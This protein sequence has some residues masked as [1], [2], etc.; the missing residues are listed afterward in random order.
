M[1]AASATASAI[2]GSLQPLAYHQKIKSLLQKEYSDVWEWFNSVKVQA[3]Y[4]EKAELELLKTTYRM[5]RAAHEDLYQLVDEVCQG[6]ELEVPVTL[7]QAQGAE[8]SSAAL[9]YTPGH[10]HVVLVGRV[11]ELLSPN[12]MKALLAHELAHFKLWESE[13]GAFLVCDQILNTMADEPRAE[14]CHHQSARLFQLYT[15]VYADAGALAVV[16]EED[17]VATLLK[18]HTGFKDADAVS[19]MKQA[20][21]IFSK[22][23]S[24]TEGITHPELFIR[25]RA[26]Q[27]M[28]KLIEDQDFGEYTAGTQELIEGKMSLN[29]LDMLGQVELERQTKLFLADHLQESWLRTED[30]QAHIG[31]FFP[32]LDISKVELEEMDL[33]KVHDSVKEYFCYLLVDSVAVNSD[34]D[35][36]AIA[37]ALFTGEKYGLTKKLTT[38]INQELKILKKDLKRIQKD[39]ESMV[40]KA[41]VEAELGSKGKSED[42]SEGDSKLP[43]DTGSLE[44]NSEVEGG[45]S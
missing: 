11:I 39:A 37:A 25:V 21:D 40:K 16:S 18:V 17:V 7:Y 28:Q 23:K 27:L 14:A 34:L 9:Y 1:S 4:N 43:G 44:T 6:L 3:E 10:G 13:E 22:D 29:E 12:E 38:L 30:M 15:E 31:Y 36:N 42:V 26:I 33:S 8:H 2:L 41:A 32:D 20:E 35:D 45:Q 5:E 24:S 19:Y